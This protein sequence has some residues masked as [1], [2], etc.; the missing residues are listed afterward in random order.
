MTT[1]LPAEEKLVTF[2]SKKF[3]ATKN[4][5][6]SAIDPVFSFHLEKW[7]LTAG[8]GGS[9]D[10][11]AGSFTIS[12]GALQDT[13]DEWFVNHSFVDKSA[14]LSSSSDKIQCDNSYGSD[15]I[16]FTRSVASA[17]EESNQSI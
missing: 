11:V 10:S 1:S 12:N 2:S 9:L 13:G 17:Y 5:I 15:G 8:F 16:E 4:S 14:V 7:S 3:A 6:S